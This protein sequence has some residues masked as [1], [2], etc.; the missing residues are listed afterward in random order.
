[1]TPTLG[2]KQSIRA[3]EVWEETRKRAATL[4]PQIEARIAQTVER[5]KQVVGTRDVAFGW[6]GGK[7]S[8]VLE[9]VMALAGYRACVLVITSLEYR[10]FLQ[11]ATDH[12]PERLTVIR[13]KHDIDWLSRNPHMLFP[14]TSDIAAKWFHEVQHW[15]QEQFLKQDRYDLLAVGRRKKDGNY[16][17]Q[18]GVYTNARGVTRFA[19]LYDWTHE[20]IFAALDYFRAELPPNYTWPRGY[21]VGT[22]PWPARQWAASEQD[23]WAEVYEIE[24]EIVIEA[25]KRLSGARRFLE[26]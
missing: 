26:G 2:R 9:R 25:A 19:P 17:G 12:M 15:G 7:D 10:A 20:E 11:W 23:G 4:A 3:Q 13:T 6:S 21:Q 18:G 1:M 22:G 5:A 8:I 16:C 24:P 14:K